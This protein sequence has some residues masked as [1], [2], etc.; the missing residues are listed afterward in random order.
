MGFALSDILKELR[1][2]VMFYMFSE[3]SVCI[4]LINLILVAL[5]VTSWAIILKTHWELRKR[6]KEIKEIEAALHSD[7]ASTKNIEDIMKSSDSVVA[8]ILHSSLNNARLVT[9]RR[10]SFFVFV[11]AAL[12]RHLEKLNHLADPLASIGSSA[13][14]LGLLGSVWCLMEG[15]GGYA[16]SETMAPVVIAQVVSESL[17]AIALGLLVKIPASVFYHRFYSTASSSYNRTR[18]LVYELGTFLI[19]GE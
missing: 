18:N 12:G 13:I 3:T 2:Y 7:Y 16:I 15:L 10:E 4:R 19:S 5:S 17:S 9:D 1:V 14:L 8:Q 6:L 11:N